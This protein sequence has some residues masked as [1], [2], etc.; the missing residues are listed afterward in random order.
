LEVSAQAAFR[1]THAIPVYASAPPLANFAQTLGV[2]EHSSPSKWVRKV[3]LDPG[4]AATL[5]MAFI[6]GP[7]GKKIFDGSL[8]LN[9]KSGSEDAFKKF[10]TSLSAGEIRVELPKGFNSSERLEFLATLFGTLARVDNPALFGEMFLFCATIMG[11]KEVAKELE[12]SDMVLATIDEKLATADGLHAKGSNVNQK[13]LVDFRMDMRRLGMWFRETVYVSELLKLA[14][15]FAQFREPGDGT[16]TENMLARNLPIIQTPK[17]VFFKLLA[18]KYEFTLNSMLHS[19]RQLTPSE[20]DILRDDLK[21]LQK[22]NSI[23]EG[24]N[25]FNLGLYPVHTYRRDVEGVAPIQV[26]VWGN[27]FHVPEELFDAAAASVVLPVG[28]GIAGWKLGVQV[29]SGVALLINATAFGVAANVVTDSWHQMSFGQQAIASIGLGAGFVFLIAGGANLARTVAV[30]KPAKAPGRVTVPGHKELTMP[31]QGTP[32]KSTPSRPGSVA[33]VPGRPVEIPVERVGPVDN[34]RLG[35]KKTAVGLPSDVPSPIGSKVQPIE[36]TRMPAIAAKPNTAPVKPSF[37]RGKLVGAKAQVAKAG[38]FFKRML[39]SDPV[40]S[41]PGQPQIVM[42]PVHRLYLAT[43]RWL[44]NEAELFING[45]REAFRRMGLTL[46]EETAPAGR[47]LRGGGRQP[48]LAGAADDLDTSPALMARGD[49]PGGGPSG[50]RSGGA[51]NSNKLTV[52]D[53]KAKIAKQKREIAQHRKQLGDSGK[54]ISDKASSGGPKRSG[55]GNRPRKKDLVQ[56]SND[57]DLEIRELETASQTKAAQAAEPTAKAEAET[58]KAGEPTAKAGEPTAKARTTG[59]PTD[60]VGLPLTS[61]QIKELKRMANSRIA[62][63]RCAQRDTLSQ[64]TDNIAKKEFVIA[65]GELKKIQALEYPEILL[66]VSPREIRRL[67]L[68]LADQKRA[69]AIADAPSRWWHPFERREYL[70]T[71]GRFKDTGGILD[72]NFKNGISKLPSVSKPSPAS[73]PSL[74][75]PEIISA[76]SLT[77]DRGSLI[78]HAQAEVP[79]RMLSWKGTYSLQDFDVTSLPGGTNPRCEILTGNRITATAIAMD[80]GVDFKPTVFRPVMKLNRPYG[81]YIGD[82]FTFLMYA[83]GKGDIRLVISSSTNISSEVF[84]RSLTR[85]LGI[86]PVVVETAGEVVGVVPTP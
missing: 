7:D 17:A 80:F 10:F 79:D 67:K 36:I 64:K 66:G 22:F 43:T 68:F 47:R 56:H 31:M 57:L 29:F 48:L 62:K 61:R 32:A 13:E 81:S 52:N 46:A 21:Q 83:N 38:T 4:V 74:N 42:S 72:I 85:N 23:A 40:P 73:K 76:K 2:D 27:E 25:E 35:S 28:A 59:Y 44:W 55:Q 19:G 78:G 86:K 65:Q 51:G 34:V 70:N 60:E 71:Y 77:R 30:A 9:P 14:K 69:K 53:L 20:W 41:V 12:V 50:G 75:S 11:V 45:H 18:L 16:F 3:F 84:G 82:D 15:K 5:S 58:G 63:A 49:G 8:L 33:K 37:F 24:F 54:T 1:D 6:I 26:T 39:F